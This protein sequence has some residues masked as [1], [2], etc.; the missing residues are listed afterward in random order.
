MA[1]SL[2]SGSSTLGSSAGALRGSGGAPSSFR[3]KMDAS[4][5]GFEA[6][7]VS[8]GWVRS[9]FDD[10]LVLRPSRARPLRALWKALG[11]DDV[12]GAGAEGKGEGEGASTGG[13]IGGG[14]LGGGDGGSGADRGGA[15]GFGVEGDGKTLR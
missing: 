4:W 10:R 3:T 6:T 8:E 13:Y 11:V 9:K 1:L 14:Q 15:V 2:S 12:V 7:G 5:V